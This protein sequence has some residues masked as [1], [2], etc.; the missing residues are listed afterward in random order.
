MNQVQPVRLA[1]DT[2]DTSQSGH[3]RPLAHPG[4]VVGTVVAGVGSSEWAVGK[5]VGA[6]L[7]LAL[8]PPVGEVVGALLGLA[9]GPRVGLLVGILEG[10]VVGL[11]V[12]IL[13]GFSVGIL[14]GLLVGTWLAPDTGLVVGTVVAGV[15]SSEWAVGSL[16][17]GL[18]EV[19]SFVKQSTCKTPPPQQV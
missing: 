9:L 19:G 12:G 3:G 5:V 15:G 1:P 11:F 2:G 10:L 18:L 13:V 16:E 6:L 14:V 8:G 7:G 17:E 4:L